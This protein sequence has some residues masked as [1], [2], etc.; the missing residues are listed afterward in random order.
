MVC[1]SFRKNTVSFIWTLSQKIYWWTLWWC[2][3]S[4]ILVCRVSLVCSKCES[5]LIILQETVSYGSYT[6]VVFSFFMYF[7]SLFLHSQF[8]LYFIMLQWIYGTRILTSRC[9]LK[10]GRYLQSGCYNHRDYH[11]LYSPHS[12]ATSCQHFIENLRWTILTFASISSF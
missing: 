5:S 9:N 4:R 11:R 3:K 10:Q 7:A 12:T 8:F 2:R 1:V 6:F